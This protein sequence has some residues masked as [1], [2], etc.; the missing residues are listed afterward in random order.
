MHNIILLLWQQGYLQGS[1]LGKGENL[2]IEQNNSMIKDH[3]DCSN[4]F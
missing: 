3:E 1:G 2:K 4:H